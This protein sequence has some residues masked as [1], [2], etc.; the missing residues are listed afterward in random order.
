M[1]TYH[2]TILRRYISEVE[3]LPVEAYH[4]VFRALSKFKSVHKL[5][6]VNRPISC[7]SFRDCCKTSFKDITSDISLCSAHSSRSG[8]ATATAN[9][10]VEV[11]FRIWRGTLF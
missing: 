2:V 4:Y 3:R 8:A 6:S 1:D 9:A 5:V 11:V 10:G 7:F